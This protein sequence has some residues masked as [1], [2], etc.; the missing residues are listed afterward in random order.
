MI[1]CIVALESESDN[2]SLCSP[3]DAVSL[4]LFCLSLLLLVVCLALFDPPV[5][6]GNPEKA[7][8]CLPPSRRGFVG[9]NAVTLST[10]TYFFSLESPYGMRA[11]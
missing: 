5:S 2:P 7:H 11:L 3:G 1:S 8:S 6:W 9:V 4:H 10:H